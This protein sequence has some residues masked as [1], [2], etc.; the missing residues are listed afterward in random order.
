MTK[1]LLGLCLIL[2]L[3]L[4]YLVWENSRVREENTELTQTIHVLIKQRE[5]S[6]N[7]I[8]RLDEQAAREAQRRER[9]EQVLETLLTGDFE[10]A[11]QPIDPAIMRLLNCLRDGNRP[12]DCH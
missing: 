1:F 4:A 12:V 7:T 5:I 8:K 11:D 2:A 9:A 6:V 10:N 3:G